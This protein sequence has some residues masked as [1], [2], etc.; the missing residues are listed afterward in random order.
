M[1]TTRQLA[2]AVV[3]LLLAGG[4]WFA[5]E[6]G[7]FSG[8]SAAVGEVGGPGPGRGPQG[9]GAGSPVVAASVGTEDTGFEV[10]AV[11]TVAARRAVLLYAE[12]SGIVSEVLFEPGTIVEAGAPLIRLEDGEQRVAVERARVALDAAQVILNRAEQ[13]ARSNNITTAALED[14]RVAQRRAEIDL[15]S[16]EL[17]LARRTLTAPFRGTI[18][19]TDIS[20]GDLVT[21]Q[22][23][24]ST[25]DDMS[26]VTVSFQLPERASGLVDIGMEVSATTEAIAGARFAGQISAVDSRVDPVARTLKVEAALPNEA[27]IL[28]P[29]MALSVRLAFEGEQRPAVPSLSVQWDRQGPYVWRLEGDT[30]RRLGVEIV[31]RRSGTVIVAGD[32][33]VGDRVIVEGLQRLR[34]GARVNLIGGEDEPASPPESGVPTAGGKGIGAGT[35][36]G[37]T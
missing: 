21:S 8:G 4:G 1:S 10:Q 20:I 28:K 12:G 11:G 26:T 22:K 27:N 15:R 13:L 33:A 29:G 6:R 9:Q 32:I 30:V 16:A 24:I 17:E 35:A 31:G 23:Q 5:F 2:L 7:L 14:A 3:I 37:R 36:E 18:G 25:L 19:L 34:D